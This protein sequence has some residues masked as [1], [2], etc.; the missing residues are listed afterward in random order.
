MKVV[1]V[2]LQI[3]RMM[4]SCVAN[5]ALHSFLHD[6][7]RVSMHFEHMTLERR[8]GPACFAAERALE[9]FY[10]Q[11]HT[12]DMHLKRLVFDKFFIA[13]FAFELFTSAVC[14]LLMPSHV[15]KSREA[16][17][18]FGTEVF[19]WDWCSWPF[20]GLLLPIAFVLPRASPR[21]PLI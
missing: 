20:V 8:L 12:F 17:V 10:S 13:Y 2:S 18:A 19:F 11:M 1:Y 21:L 15:A 5:I 16:T 9:L 14:Y 7:F 6:Q 3:S 4:K